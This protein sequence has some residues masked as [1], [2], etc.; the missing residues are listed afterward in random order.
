MQFGILM[1]LCTLIALAGHVLRSSQ[2]WLQLTG[3]QLKPFTI[4][5][6]L[7]R[8]AK[9]ELPSVVVSSSRTL[10]RGFVGFVVACSLGAFAGRR[11]R[12]V[13]LAGIFRA[14]LPDGTNDEGEDLTEPLRMRLEDV[15]DVKLY[16]NE[17]SPPYQKIAT[18]LRYYGVSFELVKG[19]HPTSDYKKIP[20]LELNGRQVNDSHIIVKNIAE[21]LT[22]KALTAKQL[23]WER[24]ITFEFQPSIEVELFSDGADFAKVA[25]FNDWRSVLLRL[26]SP[27]IGL[28]VGQVFR[29]RYGDFPAPPD[30]GK[31]FLDACGGQP[32]FHGDA[33]GIVDLSLFGTYASI[34][35]KDS[36]CTA[37]FLDGS[38]L[39]PWHERML[40]AV[41]SSHSSDMK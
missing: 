15:R 25:G 39:R 26:V 18:M 11:R 14:A 30:W 33:P 36:R 41:A 21:V 19:R 16:G 37:A 2:A 13:S 8:P 17:F 1:I 7:A 35:S 4:R 22:A 12:R 23:E 5:G 20:V 24:R 6:T 9:H 27:L 3:P 31:S 32:F 38:G 28:L 10:E 34:A 40:S 29:S